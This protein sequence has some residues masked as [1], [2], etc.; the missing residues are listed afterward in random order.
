MYLLQRR[1][2]RV[3]SGRC[4]QQQDRQQQGVKQASAPATDGFLAK[5]SRVAGAPAQPDACDNQQ[6][7]T[8]CWE[9]R[10]AVDPTQPFHYRVSTYCDSVCL[11]ISSSRVTLKYIPS[12]ESHTISHTF[13]Y[14]CACVCAH[15]KYVDIL[16]TALGT[17]CTHRKQRSSSWH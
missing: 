1:W 10:L 7:S 5:F 12:S 15:N 17:S 4:H 8:N 2:R 3:C 6:D 14:L 11:N 13:M 9:N 16:Y